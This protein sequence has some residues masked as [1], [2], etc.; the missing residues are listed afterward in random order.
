MKK[1][2]A[3]SLL[4]FAACFSLS[5]TSVG[6]LAQA[7]GGEPVPYINYASYRIRE[8]TPLS[9]DRVHIEIAFSDSTEFIGKPPFYNYYDYNIN[10]TEL[11]TICGTNELL[12]RE[13]SKDEVFNKISSYIANDYLEPNVY[14]G[15]VCY[16]FEIPIDFFSGDS[17]SVDFLIREHFEWNYEKNENGPE[18]PDDEI[19]IILDDRYSFSTLYY[20]KDGEKIYFS[21]ASGE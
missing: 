17:G 20:V 1:I 13:F 10:K 16:E 11:I 18:S 19:N 4:F 5:I 8:S 9:D 15:S 12:L 6:I 14:Y 7:S 3:L 2:K 21:L